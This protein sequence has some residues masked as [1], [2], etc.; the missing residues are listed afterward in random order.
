MF[1]TWVQNHFFPVRI[2]DP[3]CTRICI[4]TKWI[5]HCVYSGEWTTRIVH[6]LNDHHMGVVTAAASLIDALVKKNPEEYKGCISLAVSRLSRVNIFTQRDCSNIFKRPSVQKVTFWCYIY[7][8]LLKQKRLRDLDN[9]FHLVFVDLSINDPQFHRFPHP[10]CLIW[11]LC[12][13]FL[14]LEFSL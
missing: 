5:N 14:K 2:Q 11:Q 6:L 4:T 8:F 13:P 7:T 9:D 1:S 3:H 12:I 10:C